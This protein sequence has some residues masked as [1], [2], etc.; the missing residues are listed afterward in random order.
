[1]TSHNK[2]SVGHCCI[3]FLLFKRV[4]SLHEGITKYKFAPEHRGLLQ[5]MHHTHFGSCLSIRQHVLRRP[6]F[7]QKNQTEPKR[8][9]FSEVSQD[10][11]NVSDCCPTAH[12][13]FSGSSLAQW[14]CVEHAEFGI[15]WSLEIRRGQLTSWGQTLVGFHCLP[16][17][18]EGFHE[19]TKRRWLVLCGYVLPAWE[20]IPFAY[21][22]H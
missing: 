15:T 17:S 19:W 2:V 13:L 11:C 4:S 14:E 12:K 6:A 7:P 20:H 18:D 21:R 9:S 5:N 1:M 16:L 22:K 10:R 3:G 8:T